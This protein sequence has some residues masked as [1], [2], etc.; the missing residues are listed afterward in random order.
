MRLI[1]YCGGNWNR[2]EQSQIKTDSPTFARST[3]VPPLHCTPVVAEGVL[4]V[5]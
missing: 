4:S 5:G 3:A 2:F 1:R